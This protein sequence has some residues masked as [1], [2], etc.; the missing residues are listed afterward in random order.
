MAGGGIGQIDPP[1]PLS[2]APSLKIR[3]GQD[4]LAAIVAIQA[5]GQRAGLGVE[6]GDDPPAAVGHPELADGVAATHHSVPDGQLA[7]LHLE[8]R[9]AET[10]TGG[11]E[12]LAGAVEPV[13][14]GPAGGQH[15]H[16]LG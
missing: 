16:L 12:L 4:E 1:I 9:L 3:P 13:H 15:D 5:D 6:G 7:V 2:M 14:L 8:T 10:A 11:Q